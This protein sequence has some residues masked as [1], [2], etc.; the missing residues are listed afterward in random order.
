MEVQKMKGTTLLLPQGFLQLPNILKIYEI[1][2][3]SQI[4]PPWAFHENHVPSYIM[5]SKFSHQSIRTS[6]KLIFFNLT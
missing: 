5:K 2:G 4:F 1:Y 6:G 3:Q